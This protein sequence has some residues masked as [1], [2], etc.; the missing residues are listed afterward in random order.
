MNLRTVWGSIRRILSANSSDSNFEAERMRGIVLAI[1]SGYLTRAITILVQILQIPLALSYLGGELFGVWALL[2]TILM[3]SG[4]LDL[5]LGLGIQNATSRI[6]SRSPGREVSIILSSTVPALCIISL[7]LSLG[8]ILLSKNVLSGVW[9]FQTT[10]GME[11]NPLVIIS[12]TIAMALPFSAFYRVLTG[13]QKGWLVSLFSCLTSVISF[14]GLIYTVNAELSFS[15]LIMFTFLPFGITP[16][17]AGFYLYRTY[18]VTIRGIYFERSTLS[19]TWTTGKQFL[20]INVGV[21]SLLY[22]PPIA[23]SSELGPEALGTWVVAQRLFGVAAQGISIFLSPLWPAYANAL[24]HRDSVWIR[25]TY[26]RTI[27]WTIPLVLI[28]VMVSHYWGIEILRVWTGSTEILPSPALLSI[29]AI[30]FAAVQLGTVAA[31]LLNGLGVLRI[32]AWLAL[33]L[34]AMICPSV[35]ILA[36]QG[37]ETVALALCIPYLIIGLPGSLIAAH[38]SITSLSK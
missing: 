4:H 17:L 32:Q 27:R 36:S 24:A 8:C 20:L 31:V 23:I 33:V 13:L 11:I 3:M 12:I 2:S 7:I 34:S 1:F 22:I 26:S 15:L 10:S 21:L 30:H 9:T 19:E 18:R 14:V 6:T 28:V 35:F 37:I 38:N 5:G 29:M 25:K 16:I